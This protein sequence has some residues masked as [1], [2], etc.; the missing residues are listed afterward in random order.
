MSKV[1]IGN[2]KGPQGD[3]GIQGE[4][5]VQGPQGTPGSVWYAGTGITGTSAEGTVFPDSGVTSAAVNDQYLNTSTGNT[6]RCSLA[7]NAA[8]AKWVYT[9]CIKGPMPE[10]VNNLSSTSTTKALS[11]KMGKQLNDSIIAAG[12][13]PKT[14][15]P[16]TNGTAYT[17]KVTI[18]NVTTTFTITDDAGN[19]GTYTYTQDG[20]T[21]KVQVTIGIG[22]PIGLPNNGAVIASI[23][24]SDAAIHSYLLVGNG[25]VDLYTETVTLWEHINDNDANIT[26]GS[27][28]T[29]SHTGTS[30]SYKTGKISRVINAV[31]TALYP[32]THAKAVWFN[33]A[34][35]KTVYDAVTD[36]MGASDVFNP[37]TTYAAGDYVIYQSA[38]YKFTAAHT[39]AW[40]ASH[41][42]KVDLTTIN[43]NLTEIIRKSNFTDRTP[44][45]S[46]I[47]T[48]PGNYTTAN[49]TL[50]GA[51]INRTGWCTT[52]AQGTSQWELKITDPVSGAPITGNVSGVAYFIGK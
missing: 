40:N 29:E 41:V 28:I 14:V 49:F 48:I 4:Q 47:I 5:G 45:A 38:L 32:I 51:N 23:S 9:G 12:L 1:L 15:I 13:S 35:E 30:Y 52:I 18:D 44:D 6:Y 21:D 24:S 25:G 26:E 33:K 10:V 20:D 46:G 34:A 39:G 22:T 3:Q 8:T 2:I 37:G 16:K 27:A 17:A 42:S 31:R 11:A 36:I 7:G 43:A 19:E 50:I